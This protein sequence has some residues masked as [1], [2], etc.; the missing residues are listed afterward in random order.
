MTT[1]E[2]LPEPDETSVEA[3]ALELLE[4]VS[5]AIHAAA[6]KLYLVEFGIMS[7]LHNAE[8][9]KVVFMNTLAESLSQVSGETWSK[10]LDIEEQIDQFLLKH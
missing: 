4:S 8:E 1:D 3:A 6:A 9:E 5:C 2:L 10:L 7:R